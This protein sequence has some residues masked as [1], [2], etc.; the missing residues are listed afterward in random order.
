MTWQSWRTINNEGG[1]PVSRAPPHYRCSQPASKNR[2]TAATARARSTAVAAE[3]QLNCELIFVVLALICTA[4]GLENDAEHSYSHCLH[5][6]SVRTTHKYMHAG[7][8]HTQ[9]STIA[10]R[11]SQPCPLH[12]MM[13]DTGAG[14]TG[15]ALS[16]LL[17]SPFGLSNEFAKKRFSKLVEK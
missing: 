8:L 14:I 2:K 3:Q 13:V 17:R 11:I 15:H 7:L 6:A 5:G 1:R 4:R 9:K 12:A 16:K 10:Y